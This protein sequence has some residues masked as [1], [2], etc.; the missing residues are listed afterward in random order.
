M[1]E[2]SF[3]F[4]AEMAPVFGVNEFTIESEKEAGLTRKMAKTS[5]KVAD[6]ELKKVPKKAENFDEK[7]R[8]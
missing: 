3:V 2:N 5:D 7:L 1:A 6:L 8:N 4:N